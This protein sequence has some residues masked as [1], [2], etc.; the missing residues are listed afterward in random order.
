MGIIST[1]NGGLFYTTRDENIIIEPYGNNCARVRASRNTRI[2]D[3]RWTLLA[4]EDC[5]AEVQLEENRGILKNGSL[6][7]VLTKYWSGF[8]I[9]FQRNG[10]TV[11]STVEEADAVT[12]Y[13]HISG[14]NYRICMKFAARDEHIYGLG[15]EQ[16]TFFD[17][18]GCTYDLE[19]RNTKSSL[20]VIYSSL[21][22]GFLW[23]NPSPGKVEFGL[24]RTV[25]TANCSYQADYLVFVGDTPAQVLNTYCRLTGFAPKMPQWAAGFWQSKCR[26]KSQED[27]VEAAR[28]Y[29]RRGIPVDA[30][31]I[32][33]F[34]WTEQGNCDFDPKYWQDPEGMIKELKEMGMRPIVS[35]WPTINP[36]SRNWQEMNERNM[37][38]RTENGQYGTFDFFG[39]QTYVDMTNPEARDYVWE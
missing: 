39:Q 19:H 5:Q 10:E 9:E 24:N 3:E 15:Q 13:S 12:R 4:P 28:E 8:Q 23:N 27:L 30:I 38:V 14:D 29:H 1:K 22:Y 11:L 21:G 26:Y 17:R 6:T 7:V 31:V 2:S 33:F 32:D 36:N 16:Q 18:K 37:L 35:Y 25:W 20:P 34:H